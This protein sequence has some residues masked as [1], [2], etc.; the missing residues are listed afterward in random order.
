MTN[1]S[2]EAAATERRYWFQDVPRYAWV[3]LALA[4]RD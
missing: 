2:D 1:G 3:V 4:A